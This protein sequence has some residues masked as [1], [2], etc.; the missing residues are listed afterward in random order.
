MTIAADTVFGPYKIVEKIG[1]GGMGVVYRALDTRLEREVALK[2]VSDSFLNSDA[3]SASPSPAGTPHS[4][5]QL[6][7]GRFLREARAA[8]TLNHPN[9][10]AIHDVGEQDGRPYLVMELLRGETLKLYLSHHRLS[11]SEVLAFGM[12]AASALAA[13]HAKGIVHR[14]IKPA[15]LFVVDSGRDRK[16]LKILD[17]GLAKKQGLEASPDS[18]FFGPPGDEET[19]TGGATDLTIP[20]STVGTAAYMSPEQAKGDPLDA[21]TDLFSLG[22][23]LYEMATGEPAFG[24]RSTAEVFAALLMKD[25]PA[26]T[27]VNPAMPA[28]LD[29][30]VAK[31]LAKDRAK[32]FSS[33]EDLLADLEAV[34]GASSSSSASSPAVKA[35]SAPSIPAA[36][37][38]PQAPIT[39]PRR[40][41]S[42]LTIG[43][44]A[45]VFVLGGALF[46]LRDHL[47]KK[48]SGQSAV[49]APG[50]TDATTAGPGAKPKT[51]KDA[52]I[53]ADFINKTG[54]P[55][56]DSTLGQSPVLDIVS[57]QHLRQSLQYLGRKQDEPVTPQIAREIGE[58]EGIKAILTGTIAPLG[59]AYLIT[60][61]AQNTA[62]GDDIASEEATAPDKEHVLDALNQ[63]TTAMRAKLGESLSS[64][65][66]LN[67]PFGQA[68]T[69]SLEAFRAYALGDEAHQKGNDIPEAMDHYKRAVELD[70]R[71]AMAWAR[72]GVLYLNTGQVTKASE[73]FTKA[74][75]LSGN[76]SEREK[77]YIAGHYYSSV[78][79]DL[80]KS[81]ETLQ[82]ATQ[83][84][85]LQI[86]NFINIGVFYLQNG[87]LEKSAAAN[88]RALVL[89]PDDAIAIE[90]GVAVGTMLDRPAVSAKYIAEAKRLGLNGTS[91]LAI[92]LQDYAVRGDWDNVQRIVTE[93]AGRPDQVTV[94]AS[95]G[96]LYP[97]FG[98]VQL[99]RTTL[100]RAADQAASVKAN[101]AQASGLLAAA[102]AGW[103][104]DECFD[105][106]GVAKRALQLDNGKV[107]QIA[108]AT[109][110][111]GCNEAKQ[112]S[113]QLSALEKRYP[114]DTLVQEVFVP[115]SRGW[116]AL[117]AGDPKQ[118]LIY[119][120]RVRSHDVA[121]FAPF[122]RGLAY[123]Q[124]KDPANAITSFKDA[125][126]LKGQAYLIGNP[127]GLSFLGMG[128]A[129]AMAGDKAN[130]KKAYDV[131]FSE[132]KNADANLP[133]V[134][135][136]K[137]EY[138]QL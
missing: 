110:L 133:I 129:Y 7:H 72:I 56:F 19:A 36:A 18:R 121:S 103:M 37:A 4:A 138:A 49:T 67:A 20:G 33:A 127:Y 6:S 28:A 32:R 80:N 128:R 25:P 93:T 24:G 42:R 131:F 117:K 90:N 47:S 109:T 64:I 75:Q 34:Q 106:S 95:L 81:I 59:K 10:C 69:P 38:P 98:Q 35:T 91:L 126:R 111:A 2:L 108:A 40:S 94:T 60:L 74:Y 101:D 104:V 41:S 65:Q 17:F 86:D 31:L 113:E 77:L 123:L 85:P 58:R 105:A 21:R 132:W 14:D 61:G 83:E 76:V 114:E 29:P 53:V 54:D 102:A 30:I 3:G 16:Q 125:T 70:P 26:V 107:T 11:V 55:V 100:L 88:D 84:Y 44:V 50:T 57:Q 96:A 78:A 82:V 52:I 97:E 120:E 79:G 130:A 112:A 71:L 116:L 115:Q 51:L 23:V 124:L 89:Q 66:R 1:A 8:A 122:M 12:Q 73:Y 15:N 92:E 5:T 27:S 46:L 45:G 63:V 13:A 118:A 136:A 9:I 119:L 48:N 39:E 99:A 62:S 134:A 43:V 87:E 22:S 137:K 68:T 135:E